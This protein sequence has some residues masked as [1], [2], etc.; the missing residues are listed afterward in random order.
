MGVVCIYQE[1]RIPAVCTMP[2]ATQVLG[3]K[4][5]LY[6]LLGGSYRLRLLARGLGRLVTPGVQGKETGHMFLLSRTYYVPE[7]GMMQ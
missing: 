5:H 4:D 6:R 1:Q 7:Q 2:V 3:P